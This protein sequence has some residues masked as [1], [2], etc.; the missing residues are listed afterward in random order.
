MWKRN[1]NDWG[2]FCNNDFL[3][4]LDASKIQ[5]QNIFLCLLCVLVNRRVEHLVS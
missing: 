1:V 2:S 3:C 4:A 5:A